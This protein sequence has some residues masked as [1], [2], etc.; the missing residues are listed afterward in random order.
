MRRDLGDKIWFFLVAIIFVGLVALYSASCDNV[1]VAQNI[2]Y[3]QFIFAVFCLF[4]MYILQ[5]IDYRK[6]Y[7]VAYLLYIFNV[8]LLIWVLIA[9]KYTLGAKRWIQIGALNFQPS[10]FMKL[11]L[12]LTLGRYFSKRRAN[13]SF[14]LLNKTQLLCRDILI[15]FFITI[16][17]MFIIFKQPDLGTA[18]LLFGIF[19]AMLFVSGLEYRYIFS[20]LG[21]C[22]GVLPF[23]WNV[24]KQYQKD[25]LLVF[26][27]PNIDPLGAGYTIIQSKIAIGSG[28]I[29]GKGWLAGTQNQLNF[30]PERHTDFIFSVIGE[31]W[32]L[33][34]AILTV[35]LYFFL[36][37]HCLNIA[38]QVKD[39]FGTIVAVGMASILTLQVVINVGMVMGLFPIVGLTLP[40]ISYGRSS[41]LVFIIMIGF[42]LNLSKRRTI[43]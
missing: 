18:L 14:G 38:S 42:L 19:L 11:S 28:Q 34:G 41:F 1:R 7:D 20:F 13:I 10:E 15:P 6:F 25:R 30:L 8:L 24:L 39:R 32:G 22:L 43:F 9:G 31:E 36:I 3:N 12:I 40:F 2:F 17:P 16:V 26:L 21:I 23:A 4:V 37:M 35:C 5:N 27:N 29:F 33:L